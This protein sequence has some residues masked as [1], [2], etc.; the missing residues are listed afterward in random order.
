MRGGLLHVPQRH[1]GIERGGDKRMP[2]RVR[3]DVLGDPGPAG[4]PPGDPGGVVPVQP[5]PIGM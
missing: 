1:P 3:A 4:N 5:P 2:K